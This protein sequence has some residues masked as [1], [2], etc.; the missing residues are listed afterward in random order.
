MSF[1]DSEP[2]FYEPKL[3]SD[4]PCNQGYNYS[5]YNKKPQ[6]S[7]FY[8]FSILFFLFLLFLFL[9]WCMMPRPMQV[10]PSNTY[11]TVGTVGTLPGVNTYPL[12]SST[13][14]VTQGQGQG[15]PAGYGFQNDSD[16][17]HDWHGGWRGYGWGSPH[18][19]YGSNYYHHNH[20]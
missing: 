15:L 10:V 17:H 9:S 4:E 18:Y 20:W 13:G 8:W 7:G 12:V 6:K 1:Y 14:Q 2:E 3:Y 19:W 5:K 11:G 16:W